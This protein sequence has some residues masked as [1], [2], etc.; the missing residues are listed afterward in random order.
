MQK[1]DWEEKFSLPNYVKALHGTSYMHD[2]G[3]IDR[4][5]RGLLDEAHT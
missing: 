5:C 2:I 3:F 1:C 4:N